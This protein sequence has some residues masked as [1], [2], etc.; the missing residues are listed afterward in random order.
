MTYPCSPS[1][2]TLLGVVL[3]PAL[4]SAQISFPQEGCCLGLGDSV[5]A[6]TGALPVTN[7]YVY[8]LYDQGLFGRKSEVALA[9]IA[10]G[11]ARS[12]DLRD[13]Q[14]SQVVVWAHA[15][16]CCDTSLPNR[17]WMASAGSSGTSTGLTSGGM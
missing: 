3:T 14:V 10:L 6:G 7:G 1:A 17:W 4:A 12:W 5:V 8:Q 15:S 16:V 13:H 9:S 11:A 2:V